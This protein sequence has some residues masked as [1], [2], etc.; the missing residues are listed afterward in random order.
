MSNIDCILIG[1]IALGIS[2]G[3]IYLVEKLFDMFMSDKK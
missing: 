3:W 1:V 2:G